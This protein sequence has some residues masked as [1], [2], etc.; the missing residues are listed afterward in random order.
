MPWLNPKTGRISQTYKP[1]YEK[2]TTAQAK[3][4]RRAYKEGVTE[5]KEAGV[6]VSK[7]TSPTQLAK[8]QKKRRKKKPAPPPPAPEPKP[9]PVPEPEPAPTPTPIT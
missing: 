5:L 9:E 2:I 8:A 1:G 7:I 6:D 3:A 4:I